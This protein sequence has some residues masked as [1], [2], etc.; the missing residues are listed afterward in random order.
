MIS[1]KDDKLEKLATTVQKKLN[2]NPAVLIGC[3]GSIP[4]GLPSMSDLAAEIVRQ[5][6]TTYSHEDIWTT[7]I[8]ELKD[9]N[10]LETA[11][12]KVTLNDEIH[13]SIVST[14]WSIIDKKDREAF[15][16]FLQQGTAPALTS[17]LKKF[18]LRAG[19]TNIIT[20]NYDRLIEYAID[21]A[22]GKVETGFSGNCLKSFCSFPA[23]NTARTVNLFKVHGCIDWFKHK[24][25]SNLMA[26][27]FFESTALMSPAN[28][29]LP[30]IVTPGNNKYKETHN[31]PFR[32]VIAEA[33]KALRKS[34]SYLCIG[35]GFNDEHIQP[36]IID[37][38]RTKNKPIVIVAKEITP[39][40]HDL[41]L[42]N[43]G[44]NCLIICENISKC[45]GSMVYYSS[46]E[47]ETFVENFWQ[48]D[49][50]YKLWF[51]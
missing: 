36:I 51:E 6:E 30:V 25:N 2:G 19:S 24:A 29:C 39:K 48:L 18:V 11:L 45:N 7:F 1:K 13:S 47:I 26:T 20:T 27:S 33:D 38:N 16:N 22:Q 3:G 12:E 17:I 23:G 28:V 41:F 40:M 32:T 14:I 37:E 21:F 35:Y 31:D 34:A 8:T 43:N 5:L 49:S 10:N 9:G 42:K 4:Y 50:F 46:A 15:N 44:C